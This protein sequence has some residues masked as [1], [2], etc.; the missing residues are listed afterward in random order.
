LNLPPNLN[1]PALNLNAVVYA[2]DFSLGSQIAGHYASLL[3][4]HFS[5]KLVV[6]HA[7]TL[8]Q[9]AMEVEVDQKQISQQRKELQF[10]LAK[11]AALLEVDSLEIISRLQNSDP[12]EAIPKLADEYAPSLIALGTHGGSRIERSLIGSVAEQILRSTRWPSLTVGP[13][14]PSVADASVPFERI[15]YA[16]DFTPAA[17]GAA[18]FAISF[19]ESF[20]AELDVLNVIPRETI[21]HPD[22]FAEIK[23]RFYSA[24]DDVVSRESIA[25]RDSRS[26]VKAGKAHQQIFDHIRERSIDLLVLGIRKT[27]HLGLQM[28]T[29]AAFQLIAEAPCPVLTIT[30]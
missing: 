29:S 8:S 12:T 11:K 3:A 14:V 23:N 21:D 28:R 10:L 1:A 22:R 5:S 13:Q 20:G 27:S 24:L 7:F 15:L 30:A 18:G 25:F 19:A 2:T 17:A 9:A 26:F 16:T 6:A 4:K